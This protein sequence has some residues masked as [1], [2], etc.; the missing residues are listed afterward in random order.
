MRLKIGYCEISS[1]MAKNGI[2]LFFQPTGR[3]TIKIGINSFLSIPVELSIMG[4]KLNC[5]YSSGLISGRVVNAL[6]SLF[7]GRF[8]DIRFDLSTPGIVGVELESING[9][10]RVLD[11]L[12]VIDIRFEGSTCIVDARMR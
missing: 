7:Q 6:L 1:L 12:D 2:N 10:K 5:K 11:I 9:M 3:R 8:G 4:G